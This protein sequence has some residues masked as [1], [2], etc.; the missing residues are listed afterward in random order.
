MQA[1]LSLVLF[2]PDIPTLLP[3]AANCRSLNNHWMTLPFLSEQTMKWSLETVSR[4]HL[5]HLLMPPPFVRNIRRTVGGRMERG[6]GASVVVTDPRGH[7]HMGQ[8]PLEGCRMRQIW[9]RLATVLQTAS[10]R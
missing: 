4:R 1:P 9:G 10:R 8:G 2:F 3:A 7:L 5:R 6:S